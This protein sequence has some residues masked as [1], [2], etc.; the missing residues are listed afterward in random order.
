MKNIN[1]VNK[2][3][4]LSNAIGY[5][6]S[7]RQLN[8]SVLVYSILDLGSSQ[9][10]NQYTFGIDNKTGDFVIGY[11]MSPSTGYLIKT[12]DLEAF[13]KYISNILDKMEI[14]VV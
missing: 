7:I 6:I 11:H 10:A 12:R 4:Q 2:F 8:D 1:L 3:I 5:N 9:E 13:I 14:E